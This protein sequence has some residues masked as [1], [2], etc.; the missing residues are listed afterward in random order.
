MSYLDIDES[1]FIDDF[2]KRKEFAQY[3]LHPQESFYGENIIPKYI[4]IIQTNQVKFAQV[5]VNLSA[6]S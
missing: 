5:L 4:V 6:K 1:E 3:K 2:N